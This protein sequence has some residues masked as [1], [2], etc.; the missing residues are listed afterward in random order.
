MY[1]LKYHVTRISYNQSINT[2]NLWHTMAYF[3]RDLHTLISGGDHVVLVLYRSYLYIRMSEIS[4][5]KTMNM[6]STGDPPLTCSC[7]KK[8]DTEPYFLH[9]LVILKYH[10]SCQNM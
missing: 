5:Y 4:L 3:E 2:T 7:Y 6:I 10:T 9:R 8:H 1:R